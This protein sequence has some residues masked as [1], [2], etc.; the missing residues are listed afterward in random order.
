MRKINEL[1]AA[2]QKAV[3][4][5]KGLLAQADKDGLSAELDQ[6]IEANTANCAGLQK[7][8][9]AAEALHAA[10]LAAEPVASFAG[11]GT[12]EISNNADARSDIRVGEDASKRYASMGEFLQDVAKV[13]TTGFTEKLQY[14]AAATG[15]NTGTGSDGGF[16][17]RTDFSTEL[18]QAASD[19]AVLYPR[20]R[21]MTISNDADGVQ[22]PFFNETSRVEGSHYGNVQVYRVAEADTV[23]AKKLKIGR[24]EVRLRELMG[25]CYVTDRLLRDGSMLAQFIKPAFGSEFAWKRDSEIFSGLG[26]DGCLGIMQSPALVTVAKETGQTAA[27]IN[28][29]NLIKMLARFNGSPANA[30]WLVNRDALPTIYTMTLGDKPVYMPGGNIN[31]APNGTILG[32]PVVFTEHNETVGTVGDIVLVDLNEYLVIEKGGLETAE[33]MHVRFEY[34]EMAFRFTQYV[35]GI[36]LKRTALTPNKG[37]NTLSPYV[38]LATRA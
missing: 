16:L 1:K 7:R 22:L 31:G 12:G 18:M 28:V 34:N 4:E 36:P 27:T 23:T 21:K 25:L 32:V 8:I 5:G 30:A 26:S 17:V 33:S 11:D 38:A 3:E 20:C 37:S 14:H 19:S 29:Q 2:L 6:Q 35:N 9:A 13:P 24:H 10:E 15:M